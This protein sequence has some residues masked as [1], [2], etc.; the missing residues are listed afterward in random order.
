MNYEGRM[1]LLRAENR[2]LVD[3]A[4]AMFEEDEAIRLR[5]PTAAVA[6][7]IWRAGCEEAVRTLYHL[8]NEGRA[9]A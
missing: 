4:T 1:K 7:H 2:V 8:R 5:R 9:V 3:L 6:A